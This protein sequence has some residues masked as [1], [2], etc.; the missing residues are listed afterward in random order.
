MATIESLRNANGFHHSSMLPRKPYV[1]QAPVFVVKPSYDLN[2]G[3]PWKFDVVDYMHH[4]KGTFYVTRG[5]PHWETK[6]EAEDWA[7]EITSKALDPKTKP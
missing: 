2:T 5:K 1:P 6:M 4:V 7:A 3:L